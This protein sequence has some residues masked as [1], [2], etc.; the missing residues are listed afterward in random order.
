M[1]GGVG[2][3]LK[4]REHGGALAA[5]DNESDSRIAFLGHQSAQRTE[6]VETGKIRFHGGDTLSVL[7]NGSDLY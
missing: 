4:K 6:L 5:W 1:R 2:F 3:Q 7:I